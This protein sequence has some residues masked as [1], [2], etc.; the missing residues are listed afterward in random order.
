MELALARLARPRMLSLFNRDS[1]IRSFAHIHHS[2][3]TTLQQCRAAVLSLL[4]C[5][6]DSKSPPIIIGYS[7]REKI[8]SSDRLNQ[9][10]F[11][12]YILAGIC[13]CW[14]CRVA[15]CMRFYFGNTNQYCASFLETRSMCTFTTAAAQTTLLE[16]RFDRFDCPR[17]LFMKN[18]RTKMTRSKN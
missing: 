8:M 10:F 9:F 4:P 13:K 17:L 5:T 1:I 3:F 7:Y 16:I 11:F 15:L 12:F 2:L 18:P 14:K 6:I